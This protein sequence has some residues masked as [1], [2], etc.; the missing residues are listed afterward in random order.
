M[1]AKEA[2]SALIKFYV[3]YEPSA[4][5]VD[6]L[7]EKIMKEIGLMLPTATKAKGKAPIV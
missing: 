4:G 1:D 7:A 6:A 2:A 3:G 5:E